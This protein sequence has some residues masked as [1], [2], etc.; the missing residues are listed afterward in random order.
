MREKVIVI[1]IPG[2]PKRSWLVALGAGVLALG[3]AAYA[4]NAFTLIDPVA[5]TPVSVAA[6]KANNQAIRDKVTEL[7]NAIT[8]LQRYTNA[9]TGQSYSLNATYCGSTA[10]TTGAVT[11]GALTGIA[12]TKSLCGKVCAASPTAHMCTT[13]EV[14]RYV[15]TGG[16]FPTATAWFSAG[17]WSYDGTHVLTDCSSWTDGTTTVAGAISYPKDPAHDQFCNAS[18][19][20]LCCD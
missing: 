16:V 1:R 9:G 10:S 12:A 8:A 13:V 20:I 18:S 5:G 11:D 7:Q 14:Q 19:P 3:A 6:L 2:W 17:V 4:F 15:A